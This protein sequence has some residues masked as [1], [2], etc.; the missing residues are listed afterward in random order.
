[1][2]GG[3]KPHI[4]VGGTVGAASAHS[5]S[6]EDSNFSFVAYSLSKQVGWLDPY[7]M[8]FIAPHEIGHQ[9]RSRLRR[10]L[11]KLV[12][13]ITLFSLSCC[14]TRS[15]FFGCLPLTFHHHHQIAI[16]DGQAGGGRAG[17]VFLAMTQNKREA[18]ASTY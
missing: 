18:W 13:I 2:C 11:K 10:D 4:H 12:I 14:V 8:T 15:H 5:F 7:E 1:M 9:P 16:T 6:R 17:H 3:D